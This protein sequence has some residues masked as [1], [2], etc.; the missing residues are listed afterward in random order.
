M[1]DDTGAL[2]SDSIA[3]TFRL[4]LDGTFGPFEVFKLEDPG[5]VAWEIFVWVP[6]T[7]SQ[8]A[9]P[10]E[11]GEPCTCGDV[12]RCV[13]FVGELRVVCFFAVAFSP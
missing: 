11:P 12:L 2:V 10:A 5:I 6:R 1:Y 4:A 8:A 9:H 7:R 3:I 13:D